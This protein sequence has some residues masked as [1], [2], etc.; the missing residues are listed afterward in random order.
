[1]IS[2]R[3]QKLIPLFRRYSFLDVIPNLFSLDV[4][5]SDVIPRG[6][7]D[8]IPS[9]RILYACVLQTY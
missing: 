1:M 8:V 5:P 2:D 6:L 4:I 3:G 9:S 7:L